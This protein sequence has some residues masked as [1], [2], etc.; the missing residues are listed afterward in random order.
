MPKGHSTH[1][2]PFFFFTRGLCPSSQGKIMCFRTLS[3]VNCQ[4]LMNTCSNAFMARD[5]LMVNSMRL[6]KFHPYI[7]GGEPLK[8]M[9]LPMDSSSIT[10]SFFPLL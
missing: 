10:Q 1:N 5:V 7:Y 4:L 2:A 8:S 3:M 6:S 9:K